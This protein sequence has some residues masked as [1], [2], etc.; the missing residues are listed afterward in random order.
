[1][2]FSTPIRVKI[3]RKWFISWKLMLQNLSWEILSTP[4]RSSEITAFFIHCSEIRTG[5]FYDHQSKGKR[6]S[7]LKRFQLNF[8]DKG[9]RKI[10]TNVLLK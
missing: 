1:M 4:L 8:I 3:Q 10:N 5:N 2:E 9:E 7:F 6:S